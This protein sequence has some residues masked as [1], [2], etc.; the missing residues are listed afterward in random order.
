LI[1]SGFSDDQINAMFMVC[2]LSL[3]LSLSLL[4]ACMINWP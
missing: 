4:H 1:Q 2:S 3:S